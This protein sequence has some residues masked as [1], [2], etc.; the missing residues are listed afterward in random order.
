MKNT[1][2]LQFPTSVS[3]L[4]RSGFAEVTS[5]SVPKHRA[6]TDLNLDSNEGQC[7]PQGL[8]NSVFDTLNNDIRRYPSAAELEQLIAKE[9]GV[10]PQRIIVTAGADEALDR[11]CRL[12]LAPGRTIILPE[13]TFE[14][15]RRYATLACGDIVSIP[16]TSPYYPLDEVLAAIDEHTALIA[17]VSP[18]NPDGKIASR[19]DLIE[20]SK[21]APNALIIVDLAYEEFA[22]KSLLET[23]ISMPNTVTLKT[24][25]KAWGLAGLRVGYAIS[26]PQ[27]IDW[28]RAAGGPYS[29]SQLSLAMARQ[30]LESS[31]AHVGEFIGK[32]RANRRVLE[33][34]LSDLGAV[35]THSQGNFAFA[36]FRDA[37]WV[38][39]GLAG[40][41][42]AI[43]IF[44][45]NASLLNSVRITVPAD[46]G[47][48]KRLLAALSTCLAPEAIV[49]D[50]DGVLADVS[51]SY[52]T[53]IISTASHFG[54]TLSPSDVD[55]AKSEP[56]SNN[57]WVVATRL[58]SRAGIGTSLQEVTEV[59]ETF[60][61]GTDRLNGLKYTESLIP[62]VELIRDLASHLPLAVVTGR[63]RADAEYFLEV[64]GI[65]EYFSAMSCMEDAPS[66]PHPAG[67]L[68][69]LSELGVS[70]AWMVGDNIADISAA[71]SAA[72]VP[73]GII[74]PGAEA[75]LA[76]EALLNAG[77]ARIIESLDKLR[78]LLP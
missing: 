22:E 8:F 4:P 17:L 45:N 37:K 76:S 46:N 19:S 61:Q 58:I 24:F 20:L 73:I 68:Q 29:V 70:R 71:R 39:D 44:P 65:R 49:F 57:D 34:A 50:M 28:M 14:M 1:A 72:V 66:K 77:A 63:P 30:A 51:H 9:L 42:I 25:S 11:I 64:S 7:L 78:E 56:N 75:P 31:H 18:N 33:T 41:G 36:R 23:A 53:A 62:S 3:F 48:F 26:H 13:P 10:K 21:A 69:V 52:R 67:V 40:L 43:R 32:I 2:K 27:I 15:I 35:V 5:Y 47:D 74:P 60:Y 38:R 16:W 6:I 55:S 59:F 54:L 12:A